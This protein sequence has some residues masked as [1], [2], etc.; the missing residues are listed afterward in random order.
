MAFLE[1]KGLEKEYKDFTLSLSMA[2]EEGEFI[3]LIGP[4]GSGKSTLLSVIAGILPPDRGE[5]LLSGDDIT[6]R[7][8]QDRGI[9]MVFQDMALFPSMNVKKNIQAGMKEKD[10]KK[11]NELAEKLLELVG[12]PGYGK[13]S[14]SSLSGGEAQRVALARSIA[15]EPRIL[16]LDEPLSSLDAPL[17]KHLRAAIRMIHDSLGITMLYVTHDR[18][19]AFAVSDRIAIM[20]D[21]RIEAFGTAEELYRKPSNLF[22][23]FFTG[24]GTAIPASVLSEGASGTLFFRPENAQIADLDA[25]SSSFPRHMIFRNAEI[26]SAEFTGDGYTLGLDWNGFQILARSIIR[27]RKKDVS[28][29]ILKEAVEILSS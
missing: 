21:G 7:R 10:R 16:L 4:S 24:E 5:I 17:R 2:I 6:G 25:D 1:I 3:S 29:I 26:V 27:P 19:E 22:T 23:A 13:R 8:I 9:G 20:H 12:L 28:V 18:E 14:I 15:A 11:R